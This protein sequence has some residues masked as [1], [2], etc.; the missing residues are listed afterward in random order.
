MWSLETTEVAVWITESL[1]KLTRQLNNS[2]VELPV[3]FKKK[4]ENSI[5][6][7]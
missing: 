2:D 5:G 3:R 1:L 4:K 7:L 6:E